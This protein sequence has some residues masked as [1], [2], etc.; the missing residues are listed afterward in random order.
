V[1]VAI[2]DQDGEHQS[3]DEILQ[4]VL[5]RQDPDHVGDIAETDTFVFFLWIDIVSPDQ[6]PRSYI[7][8]Q[9][10]CS[11]LGWT[12]KSNKIFFL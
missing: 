10:V 12:N 4:P 3:S 5:T 9:L 11:R 1:H 7:S 8:F 6:C 2:A